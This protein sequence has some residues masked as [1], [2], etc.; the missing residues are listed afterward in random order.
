[1]GAPAH[2]RD[3]PDP[4]LRALGAPRGQQGHLVGWPGGARDRVRRADPRVRGEDDEQLAA[5]GEQAEAGVRSAELSRKVLLL[6]MRE[7]GEGEGENA[8]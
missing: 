5:V 6:F 4:L 2:G 1:M 8:G 3:A 7:G